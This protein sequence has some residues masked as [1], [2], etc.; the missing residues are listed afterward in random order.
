M[1]P[2]RVLF[3]KCARI[4]YND[5]RMSATVTNG[6]DVERTVR[7]GWDGNRKTTVRASSVIA[8][9]ESKYIQCASGSTDSGQDE[10]EYVTQS[11]WPR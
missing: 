7:L 10:I 9:N 4:S 2:R 11:G 8:G 3:G 6:C 5:R 1:N